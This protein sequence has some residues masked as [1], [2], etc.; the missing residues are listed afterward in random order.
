MV[1][2]ENVVRGGVPQHR[3]REMIVRRSLSFEVPAPDKSIFMLLPFTP[4]GFT[5]KAQHL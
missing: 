3:T 1:E 5:S 4:K 2:L